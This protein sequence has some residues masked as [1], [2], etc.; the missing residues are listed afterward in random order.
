MSDWP[1]KSITVRVAWLGMLEDG[2]KLQNKSSFLFT[3]NLT[4]EE[5]ILDLKKIMDGLLF[6]EKKSA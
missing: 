4:S 6:S 5:F 3:V 2:I 1:L